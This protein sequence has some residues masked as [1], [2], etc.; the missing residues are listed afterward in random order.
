MTIEAD[1]ITPALAYTQANI[2][3]LMMEDEVTADKEVT[4]KM[5]DKFKSPSNWKI[6]LRQWRLTWG[7]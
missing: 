7:N 6:S 3:T 4:A 1:D 2:R 5:P